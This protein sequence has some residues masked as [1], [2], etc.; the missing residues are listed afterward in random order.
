VSRAR[1]LLGDR[2]GGIWIDAVTY[3]VSIVT[4]TDADVQ[5]LSLVASQKV[6][7]KIF[8]ATY[9]WADL[10]AFSEQITRYMTEAGISYATLG[11]DVELGTV[12]VHVGSADDSLSATLT[13]VVPAGSFTVDSSGGEWIA[14][15]RRTSP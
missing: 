15:F 8:E 9:S 14:R 2:Y 11:P 7:V 5:A 13:A 4:P 3:N 12:L 1:A 6:T 10:V